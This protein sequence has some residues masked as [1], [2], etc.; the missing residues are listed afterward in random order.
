MSEPMSLPIADVGY[1]EENYKKL[2]QKEIDEARDH[3]VNLVI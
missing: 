3:N 2:S 1:E